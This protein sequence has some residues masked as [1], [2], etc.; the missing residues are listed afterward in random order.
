MRPAWEGVGRLRAVPI[1]DFRFW[2]LDFGLKKDEEGTASGAPTGHGRASRPWGGDDYDYAYENEEDYENEVDKLHGL[3]RRDGFYIYIRVR[4]P[5]LVLS[6]TPGRW[7]P[8]S[9]PGRHG[10]VRGSHPPL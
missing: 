7:P 9:G 5:P 1:L 6:A 3:P 2:I 10:S 8:S 4:S